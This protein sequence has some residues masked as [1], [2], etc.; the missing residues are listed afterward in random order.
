VTPQAIELFCGCGGMS[1]GLLDAGIGVVAGF[2]NN[3]PSVTAFNYNHN[4]RGAQGYVADLTTQTGGQTAARAGLPKR[5]DLVAG[6]PPCQP[7]SIAG[8]R[9]GTQDERANLV[10]SFSNHIRD[11]RP[12]AFVFE[13]VPNIARI[14]DGAL[15]DQLK[16]ELDSFG[17]D[18]SSA[19]LNAAD[20][21]V[22]QARRRFVMI[23]V[24]K[25]IRFT[26]PTP[27]HSEVPDLYEEMKP[28]VTVSEA[29]GDLPD[30]TDPKAHE[31]PNHDPTM[32][33][34]RMIEAFHNLKPGT[35]DR[36][37]YHDRLHPHRLGYTLRAGSGNFSPLRPVHYKYDRV[38]TVRESA[39]LQGMT[40]EFIWPDPLPR[41][42]QYRQVGNAVPPPLASAVATQIVKTLG[43]QVDSGSTQGD[44]SSRQPAFYL[45]HKERHDN[46]VARL[47]G[48]SLGRS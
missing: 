26:F 2:D 43:W 23:G 1:T 46:R 7:F 12:T 3:G 48:A 14:D 31:I 36:K 38:I 24:P 28:Y 35:R 5:I 15:I 40:D 13:N 27:T 22:P 44:P 45:T 33:S 25:G 18:V 32:H 37:S 41:L 4:Y 34:K 11:L 9:L 42:Q 17:Y 30:V 21:G 47:R 39:R 19:V 8:K 10:F 6:G 29:I 16:T 20:Y